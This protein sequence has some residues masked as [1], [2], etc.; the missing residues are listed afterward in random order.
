MAELTELTTSAGALPVS[1]LSTSREAPDTRFFVGSGKVEE[2][3]ERIRETEANLVVFDHA[4][5]PA[6]ERNLERALQCRVLD[7][8]S[9]IL[10]IFAQRAHTFEGQLQVELAQLRH[11]STRLVR[12]LDS[13]GAP[14]GWDRAARVPVRSS[15]KPTGDCS[16]DRIKYIN[17]RLQGVQKR[18]ALSR[19]SRGKAAGSGGGPGRLYERGKVHPVQSADGC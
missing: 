10:D 18:R 12:G 7:R 14:E 11:L 5:S 6:Q 3:A 1:V 17:R 13:P 9:L 4:L 15:W 8:I 16:V 19:R 2:I